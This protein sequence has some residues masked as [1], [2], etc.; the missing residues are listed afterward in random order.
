MDDHP[1][2]N[3][4]DVI[5]AYIFAIICNIYLSETTHKTCTPKPECIIGIKIKYMSCNI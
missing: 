3:S 5:K 4:Y 2:M 1:P